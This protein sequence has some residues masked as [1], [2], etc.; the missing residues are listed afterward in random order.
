MFSKIIII[1]SPNCIFFIAAILIVFISVDK[2]KYLL[3]ASFIS[4]LSEAIDIVIAF[5]VDFIF[6]IDFL[7]ILLI[8]LGIYIF[9]LIIAEQI[10]CRFIGIF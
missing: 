4:L 10:E 6:S 5:E 2:N 9:I 8:F 7:I 3:N 1:F